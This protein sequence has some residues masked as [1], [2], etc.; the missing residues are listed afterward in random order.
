MK[1]LILIY[2]IIFGASDGMVCSNMNSEIVNQKENFA[3]EYDNLSQDSDS[4]DELPDEIC[5]S[6]SFLNTT[7]S[8]T[9][10][11]L[12]DTDKELAKANYEL[13]KAQKDLQAKEEE[14]AKVKR[15]LQA[16]EEELAKAQED[17]QTKDA[18]L[19]KIKTEINKLKN[20]KGVDLEKTEYKLTD[21]NDLRSIL[22]GYGRALPEVQD[23]FLKALESQNSGMKD[24]AVSKGQAKKLKEAFDK[25]E[26]CTNYA[27]MA[28]V[29]AEILGKQDAE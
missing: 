2:A 5:K 7:L 14:L 17:L 26:N 9:W 4:E 10:Q 22:P 8:Q 3:E 18:E 20:L 15:D 1:K 24:K 29:A 16:K 6:I 21:L 12:I 27:K 23:G 28:E 13:A 25:A 19:A 11:N